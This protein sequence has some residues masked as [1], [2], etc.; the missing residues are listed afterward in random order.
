MVEAQRNGCGVPACDTGG[1][2]VSNKT[3]PNPDDQPPT[4]QVQPGLGGDPHN[5]KILI[6]RNGKRLPGM[7]SDYLQLSWLRL[8]HAKTRLTRILLVIGSDFSADKG[9]LERTY[10]LYALIALAMAIILTWLGVL[11]AVAAVFASLGASN[12][13]ALCRLSMLMPGLLL[14]LFSA[15]CLRSS[16]IRL[17]HADISFVASSPVPAAVVMHVELACQTLLYGVSASFLGYLFA[18]GLQAALPGVLPAIEF[19]VLAALLIIVVNL[20]SWLTGLVRL[21]LKAPLNRIF[22]VMF[23]CV[24]LC[25]VL[26]LSG[27]IMLDPSAIAWVDGFLFGLLPRITLALCVALCGAFIVAGVALT[28][29]STRLSTAVLISENALY[30][31]LYP[32]RH[33]QFHDPDSYASL[34]RRKKLAL[35]GARIGLPGHSHPQTLFSRALLSHLRQQEGLPALLIMGAVLVP[36]GAFLLVNNLSPL[37]FLLWITALVA[38][39]VSHRELT[40]VFREDQRNR[41]I[42]DHLPFDT[43][44]LLFRDSLPAILFVGLVS[45]GTLALLVPFGWGLMLCMVFAL[46]IVLAAVVCTGLDH[47]SLPLANDRRLSYEL[48]L[49]L[50]YAVVFMLSWFAPVL[51]VLGAT[52][53][54]A[55]YAMLLKR[56]SE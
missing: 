14:L 3:R 44:D 11:N 52:V 10:Q 27:R 55:C 53:V 46:L 24:L 56:G 6:V 17:S 43:T 4:L 20:A 32:V 35:R 34:R 38:F 7:I 26:L 21:L 31:E 8:R 47:V 23:M 42:R 30:A 9:L 51:G 15:S 13:K 16:P 50:F 25:A 29:L 41:M 54:L 33:L 18:T 5:P 40:R 39:P 48:S 45:L 22:S 49:L 1:R 2:P 37:L 12:A 36:T 19:A 28:L